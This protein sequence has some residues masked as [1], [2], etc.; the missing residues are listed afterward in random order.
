MTVDMTV[1][2]KQLTVDLSDVEPGEEGADELRVADGVGLAGGVRPVVLAETVLALVG[3][4][5]ELVVGDRDVRV[6]LL[7]GV[8]D[9]E[10]LSPTEVS[11]GKAGF[12][13]EMVDQSAE[14]EIF[15]EAEIFSVFPVVNAGT[16]QTE[17]CHHLT[18]IQLLRRSE[19]EGFFQRNQVSQTLTE[20][21]HI[22]LDVDLKRRSALRHKS[23]QFCTE[24]NPTI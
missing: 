10:N 17:L 15:C 23:N 4:G 7:R 3:L 6:D 9:V 13:V 1:C 24:L 5:L 19:R 20:S 2:S 16:H 14:F 22:I 18:E 21:L 8:L 12:Q 11:E